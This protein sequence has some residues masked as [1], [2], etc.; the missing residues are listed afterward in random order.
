M[1]RQ[2]CEGCDE[3]YIRETAGRFGVQFREHLKYSRKTLDIVYS[4]ILVRVDD[5]NQGESVRV[6]QKR[7]KW[8]QFLPQGFL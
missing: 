3:F 6:H 1:G 7:Y 8:E 5:I 2:K 4:L